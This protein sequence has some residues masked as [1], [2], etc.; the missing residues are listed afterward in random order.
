MAPAVG[1]YKEQK[2]KKEEIEW[3]KALKHIGDGKI[4]EAYSCVLAKH[5]DLLLIR[6][7]GRTGIVIE[8]LDSHNTECLVKR[9]LDLI[10]SREFVDFLLPWISA[11]V[12]RRVQMS[13]PLVR[14]IQN[15]LRE[16]VLLGRDAGIDEFQQ[17]EVK[18]V[19]AVLQ[20]SPPGF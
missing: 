16:L 8:Q 9:M 1:F 4:N 10:G 13:I 7:I 17:C 14:S 5:D 18:R 11:C 19:Y 3:K 2:E 15:C 12:D 20:D 6:L